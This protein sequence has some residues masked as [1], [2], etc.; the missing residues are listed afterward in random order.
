M[1]KKL[2]IKFLNVGQGDCTHLILPGGE[3]MLIDINLDNKNRGLDVIG[4]LAENLPDS[5]VKGKP[6]RLDYFV[7]THPHDDHIRGA[8]ALGNDFDIGEMWHSGHELDLEKGDCPEYDKYQAMIK[9]LGDKAKKVCAC[10]DPY[11]EI[12]DV[13]VHIFRPSQYVKPEKDK[14]E[15]EK[16]EAIH[17]ECMVVRVS[18]AGRAVM[19]T[20]D[21]HKGAWESIVKHYEDDLL[22][23]DV[24]H[25]S[26]HGSRTFYKKRCADDPAW[27]KHLDV[28]NPTDVVIS[29]GAE[30]G[31]DHPHGDMLK[32]YEKRVGGEHVYRTDEQLTI[33]LTID[34]DGTMDWQADDPDNLQ[35]KYELPTP[36]DDG[37]D[38]NGGGS[39]G[40]KAQ[41]TGWAGVL[42]SK[43][44]LGD[45]SITA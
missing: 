25:A 3:H 34:E 32:E 39:G 24:L 4:Y 43:T 26:H 45:K 41:T 30:N 15:S 11:A 5:D 12:G 19:F 23:A 33:V 17:S 20:G 37:S 16:R 1:S 7:A 42:S 18:Y 29:V 22:K 44:T 28:I 13:T 8:G 40:K 6:H 27:T 14:T 2:V 21:S 9:D 35:D 31:H 36:D 38:G 10:A